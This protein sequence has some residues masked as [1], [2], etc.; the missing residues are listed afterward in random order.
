MEFSKRMQRARNTTYDE[1]GAPTGIPPM[2]N[3]SLETQAQVKSSVVTFLEDC[4]MKEIRDKP[5]GS[6]HCVCLT[7]YTQGRAIVIDLSNLGVGVAPPAWLQNIEDWGQ[8]EEI[9]G[10]TSERSVA[11]ITRE[12]TRAMLAMVQMWREDH[13][14]IPV[15]L[16]EDL[17]LL[18]ITGRA[19]AQSAEAQPQKINP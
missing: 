16:D 3:M 11:E 13:E 7:E 15:R 5:L 10:A 8:M 4:L 9:Q 6:Q 19:S 1:T 12:T 18:F 17:D 2:P 14:D